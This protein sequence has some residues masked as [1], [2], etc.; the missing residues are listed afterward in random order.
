MIQKTETYECDEEELDET[1]SKI[2][3]KY[4]NRKIY[5]KVPKIKELKNFDENDVCI[6]IGTNSAWD[7]R[8]EGSKYIDIYDIHE[9]RKQ[10][11]EQE[12]I[13]NERL[14]A[15]ENRQQNIVNEANELY[16]KDMQKM[17]DYMISHVNYSRH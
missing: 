13:K 4:K 3:D 12:R 10:I 7:G 9:V 15:E 11:K 1:M 17:V 14:I 5:M 8:P 2:R 6:H 16:P